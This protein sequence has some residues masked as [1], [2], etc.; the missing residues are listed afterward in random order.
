[1]KRLILVMLVLLTSCFSVPDQLIAQGPSPKKQKQKIA[2][3]QK[4]LES[5]EKEQKKIESDVERLCLAIDEA[6][7]A[8]IRRQLDDHEQRGEKASNLFKEEREALYRMIESG[9]SPSAFEAQ[10]ELD[11]ILR[12]ITECS[13][14]DSYV[15]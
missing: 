5:A 10:V 1:M 14:E 8:L 4:K 13:S 3:L 2:V 7:L 6:Q 9:P 15:F 12:L 11:R